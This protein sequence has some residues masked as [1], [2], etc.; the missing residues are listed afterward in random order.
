MTATTQRR[1]GP[2]GSG[3]RRG[4]TACA[5]THLR[6]CRALGREAQL[7]LAGA[8]DDQVRRFV[9]VA[10]RVPGVHVHVLCVCV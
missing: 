3:K 6:R 2:T 7:Q 4:A 5:H 10:V 8:G 9:L 1:R